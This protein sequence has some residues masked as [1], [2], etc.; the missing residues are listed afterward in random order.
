MGRCD[1]ARHNVYC[2]L[3][4]RRRSV[5]YRRAIPRR[6]APFTNTTLLAKH[7]KPGQRASSHS[8]LQNR[9]ERSIVARSRRSRRISQQCDEWETSLTSVEVAAAATIVTSLRQLLR[10]EGEHRAPMLFINRNGHWRTTPTGRKGRGRCCMQSEAAPIT[11]V[12]SRYRVPATK[13]RTRS[14]LL[15]SST[16]EEEPLPVPV[17][18]TR[19]VGLLTSHAL[20]LDSI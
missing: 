11:A 7:L 13:S 4:G 1:L 16:W 8:S 20:F 14:R 6:L 2:H 17:Q 9:P 10:I 3:S 19:E 5:P 18:V 15:T 12:Q